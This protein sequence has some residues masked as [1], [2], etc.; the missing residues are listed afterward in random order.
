[1]LRTAIA[2]LRRRETSKAL[3]PM[4]PTQVQ[5]LPFVRR[6]ECSW[7]P[8]W[9]RLETGI[10][11]EMTALDLKCGKLSGLHHLV[12][13]GASETDR[14]LSTLVQF[15]SRRIAGGRTDLR[16]KTKRNMS[17]PMR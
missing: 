13:F 16:A 4:K 15:D 11:V 14:R 6:I 3:R 9:R 12:Q 17:R 10:V 1:M 8:L 2:N 7:D 5:E